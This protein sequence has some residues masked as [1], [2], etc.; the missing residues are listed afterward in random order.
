MPSLKE[1][2]GRIASVGSTLKITSAMK[3][4]AAAKLRKAQKAIGNMLPY[5]EA[6]TRMLHA[7]IGEGPTPVIPGDTPVFP[8]EAKESSP[9]PVAYV[10]FSS[11]SSLCGGFN[12]SVIRKALEAVRESVAAGAE[13]TV[14]SVGRKMADAMR[15]EGFPSPHDYAELSAKCDYA[16]AAELAAE[17]TEGFRS[18]RFG[19]VELIYNHY[20][21]AA[22]QPTLR[23]PYLPMTPPSPVVPDPTPVIPSEAQESSALIIE[24]DRDS[25]IRLLLPKVLRLKIYATL[26]DSATAEQAARTVAMQM[27]SDNAEALLADLTLEYNKTRQQKITAEILDLEGGSLE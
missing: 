22:A 9:L 4:V 12:A 26:L 17:L 2:K 6:L 3:M 18:G 13:V 21:S 11:N 14:Y 19:R 20:K 15:R 1:I 25:V 7:L 8:G 10:C 5:E 23:E 16:G 27:A 24:P